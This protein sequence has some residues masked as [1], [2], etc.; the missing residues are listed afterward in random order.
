MLGKYIYH[1]YAQQK[2]A[3]LTFAALYYFC[4]TNKVRMDNS[5]DFFDEWVQNLRKSLSRQNTFCM[6]VTVL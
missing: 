4:A 3:R 1:N 6:V 2:I 5:G